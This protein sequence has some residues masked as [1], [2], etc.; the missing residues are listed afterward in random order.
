[1]DVCVWVNVTC[2]ELWVV[3]DTGNKVHLP[4]PSFTRKEYANVMVVESSWTRIQER[5]RRQEAGGRRQEAGGRR[6]E[7]GGRRQEAG[8][9]RQEAGPIRENSIHRQHIRRC[10]PSREQT[11][12]LKLFRNNK[13]DRDLNWGLKNQGRQTI[14]R[15]ELPKLKQMTC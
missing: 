3:D 8:G 10:R 2:K 11:G 9:R 14:R 5:G 15:S 4:L 12:K 7:A 13:A 1:M 6:Q